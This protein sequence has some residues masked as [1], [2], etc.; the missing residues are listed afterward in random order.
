MLPGSRLQST[1][2]IIHAGFIFVKASSWAIL[3]QEEH[4]KLGNTMIKSL[5]T[6]AALVIGLAATPSFAAVKPVKP[7]MHHH[8]HHMMMKHHKHHWHR[9]HH[10]HHHVMMKKVVKK[11]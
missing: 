9:H 11:K 1:R 10:L 2:K 3:D 5:L 7:V 4:Q 8:H 6:A